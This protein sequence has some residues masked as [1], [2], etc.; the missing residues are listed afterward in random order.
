MHKLTEV[1]LRHNYDGIHATD[2]II[3]YIAEEP[4]CVL[5]ELILK[6]YVSKYST[7]D[8][9]PV[10]FFGW[11]YT[12]AINDAGY[13]YSL[14]NFVKHAYHDISEFIEHNKP[15]IELAE[16]DKDSNPDIV[17]K[18]IDLINSSMSDDKIPVSQAIFY[19]GIIQN[20]EDGQREMETPCEF[21]KRI[22]D[23]FLNINLDCMRA[24]D[25][26]ICLDMQYY[27]FKKLRETI[28]IGG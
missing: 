12:L 23:F 17:N 3:G 9:F 11:D 1:V 27:I 5:S 19:N 13:R 18:Y 2:T 14:N 10:G 7:H 4:I 16:V 24:N 22:H 25:I 21:N 26:E 6:Y 28:I 15:Y 20:I 8:I